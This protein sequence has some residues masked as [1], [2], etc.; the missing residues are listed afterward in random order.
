MHFSHTLAVTTYEVKVGAHIDRPPVA[1]GCGTLTLSPPEVKVPTKTTF[2][3]FWLMSMNPPHLH[4]GG[5]GSSACGT[6]QQVGM[7][8]QQCG[9]HGVWVM[10]VGGGGRGMVGDCKC[11]PRQQGGQ[12]TASG[13]GGEL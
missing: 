3:A 13:K 10:G 11:S 4:E 7:M 2:L 6:E 5:R 1:A 8:C 12:V 9:A